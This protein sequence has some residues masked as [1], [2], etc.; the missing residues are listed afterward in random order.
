MGLGELEFAGSYRDHLPL[1]IPHLSQFIW[2]RRLERLPGPLSRLQEEDDTA[3]SG[4]QQTKR[5]PPLL[6]LTLLSGPRDKTSLLYFLPATN[7][8]SSTF[9]M[10]PS[11]PLIPTK[12]VTE[13]RWSQCCLQYVFNLPFST[14]FCSH[15]TMTVLSKQFYSCPGSLAFTFRDTPLLGNPFQFYSPL[16]QHFPCVLSFLGTVSH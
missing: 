3:V 15:L 7:V 8:T 10:M 5:L 9:W 2:V 16:K 12:T 14:F 4:V 11:Q 6:S 13:P 1:Y